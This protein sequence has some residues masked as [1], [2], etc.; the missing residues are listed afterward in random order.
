MYPY[1]HQIQPLE[2][3]SEEKIEAFEKEFGL[4]LPPR[5]KAFYRDYSGSTM[6]SL[7]FKANGRHYTLDGFH[8]LFTGSMSA[9]HILDIY[10]QSNRLPEGYFPLGVTHS[11]DDFF[12][13]TL[14]DKVYLISMDQ[15]KNQELVAKSLDN[16]FDLLDDAYQNGCEI[17]KSLPSRLVEF[18]SKKQKNKAISLKETQEEPRKNI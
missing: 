15:P 2:T 13:D 10:Q 9:E 12:Y 17:P 1:L 6:E 16:F 3:V 4:Q 5:L 8:Q 14:H 11:G 7:L 18:W